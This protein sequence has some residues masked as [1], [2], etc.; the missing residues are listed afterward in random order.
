MA[1]VQNPFT[2][3]I[4]VSCVGIFGV[5]VSS[6]TIRIFDRRT[7]LF[8]GC[9]IGAVAQLISA[10]VF[11]AMPGTVVAGRVLI[12]FSAIF[13][14]G[15]T[16][17]VGPYAWAVAAELCSTRLRAYTIGLA[18]GLNFITAWVVTYTAPLFVVSVL[19]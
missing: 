15:Y 8:M 18:T 5:L 10:S 17:S 2:M 6:Y 3:S 14:F 7:Q 4:A 13:I 19:C 11:A 1:G 9:A 12:A 16:M